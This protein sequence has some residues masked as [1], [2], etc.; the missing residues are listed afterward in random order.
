MK[1]NDWIE[2]LLYEWSD[3]DHGSTAFRY[4]D[5]FKGGEY[6]ID[7]YHLKAVMGVLCDAFDNLF[8]E[9]ERRLTNVA[10]DHL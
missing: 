7:F 8:V 3:A 2:N 6:W 10:P 4:P 5:G 9:K 1:I